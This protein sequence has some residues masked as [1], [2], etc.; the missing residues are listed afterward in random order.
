MDPLVEFEF[1]FVEDGFLEMAERIAPCVEVETVC[2]DDDF[3]EDIAVGLK[4]T[5]PEFGL[6]CI[7]DDFED[8]KSQPEFA[9]LFKDDTFVEGIAFGL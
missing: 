2:M 3:G 6:V 4:V 1:F 7:D 8:A 5:I 9:I